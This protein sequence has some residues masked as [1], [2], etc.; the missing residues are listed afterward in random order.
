MSTDY[1]FACRKCKVSI[2]VASHGLGGFQFY[3]NNPDC[4]LKLHKFL[5]E[6]SIGDHDI[7][8]IDENQE[9]DDDYRRIEWSR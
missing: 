4:M 7:R 5:E 3:R 9:M 6:H 8:F 1:Y 2:D